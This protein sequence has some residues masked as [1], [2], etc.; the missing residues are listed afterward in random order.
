MTIADTFSPHKLHIWVVLFFDY[1]VFSHIWQL[2][3]ITT[4]SNAVCI[5]N[6]TVT[7]QWVWIDFK[8]W[9]CLDLHSRQAALHHKIKSTEVSTIYEQPKLQIEMLHVNF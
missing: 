8:L 9:E 7:T 5:C 3:E 1:L 2:T 4:E 6:V